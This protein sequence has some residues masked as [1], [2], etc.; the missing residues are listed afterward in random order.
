MESIQLV[1]R[2]PIIVS[3]RW[4]DLIPVKTDRGHYFYGS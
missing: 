4:F 1:A 2:N 3:L